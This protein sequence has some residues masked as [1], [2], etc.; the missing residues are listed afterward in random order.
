MVTIVTRA[1]K[2]SP[3][4]NTEVDANFTNLNTG[5]AAVGANTD[6]TSV[7]L[8]TGTISTAPSANTDIAN[9]LY[10]DGIAS[11]LNF[12]SACNYATIA[13]LAANTYN[14]GSS[15]V[16]AT[17][18]AVAVGTL[19]ID[20]Y[21]LGIGDVGKRLLIKNEV[22][23]ANNGVYTLTQAGTAVLPY[24]LT[25]A[26][27]YDTSG[28]GTNEID[29]GDFILVLSG[30]SLSNS[31]WVQQTPLP[32]TVGTTAIT[33][34]QFAAPYVF[35]YPAAGIA[36][37]TGSAWGTSYSTTGTGTTVVLATA[38]SIAGIASFTGTGAVLIPVGTTAQQPTGVAGYLRFNTTTTQF[39]GHN[40]T[41]WA[42]VGGAAISNDTT[43]ATNVYPL[44]AS[45]TTGTALT[46]YTSNAKYLYKPSTGEL[47]SSIVNATNGIHVNSQTVATSYTIATGN[48]AM[49]VGKMTIASGQSVTVS[50]GSRWV[51]L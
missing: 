32:I 34:T 9:K 12:H 40:G 26:T 50:S 21:T 17:L 43:T 23:G 51:I 24:I 11:G 18:T 10:V 35:T 7:A 46:V 15:G 4:T 44:F 36:N 6:I 3:L 2:G 14:N 42:S 45:A 1:G 47:Q 49:S 48:S 37:S 19:T 8:T 5:K 29:A 39:E 33:F 27:D 41:T 25:R 31:S 30:S 13:A 28:S 38:P 16:G 20:G 22:A